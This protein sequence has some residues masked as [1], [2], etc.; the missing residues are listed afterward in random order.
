MAEE[1]LDKSV[2]EEMLR[3]MQEEAGGAAADAEAPKE[4][5]LEAQMLSAL[6]AT[7]EPAAGEDASVEAAMLQAMADETG[8]TREH[9]EA[10]LERIGASLPGGSVP[11]ENLKRLLNVRLSVSIELGK[12]HESINTLL[13]WTEGSLI[14]LD[15]VSGEPVDVMVN[16]KL[17]A[18]GEVVVIAENFG[19]RLTEILPA[20]PRPR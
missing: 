2:E 3:L 6:G 5:D 7:A 4:D 11:P 13:H 9:T 19:V 8:G 18:R 17:Y 1:N 12:T 20:V 14:E 10:A 15:K 16:N